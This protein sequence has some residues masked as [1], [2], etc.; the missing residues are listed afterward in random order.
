MESKKPVQKAIEFLPKE[1]K[2][3]QEKQYWK[4]FFEGDRFKDGFEWYADFR[5]LK[6]YMEPYFKPAAEGPVMV[7]VPG[8]GNSDL[9]QKLTTEMG[10]SG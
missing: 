8:C 7:M 1:Q 6:T 4:K 9:S 10:L 5:D 2:E 3:L